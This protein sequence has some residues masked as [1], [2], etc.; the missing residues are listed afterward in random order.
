MHVSIVSLRNWSVDIF[1]VNPAIIF[2]AGGFYDE[3][4]FE[5]FL[6]VSS[7]CSEAFLTASLGFPD[8]F[9]VVIW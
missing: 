4:L 1:F 8:D 5:D 7:W 2:C 9:L 6:A 3:F